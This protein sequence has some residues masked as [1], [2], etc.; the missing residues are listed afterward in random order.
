MSEFVCHGHRLIAANR[1]WKATCA[2][3]LLC[4]GLLLLSR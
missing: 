2:M 3:L 1:R 4:L